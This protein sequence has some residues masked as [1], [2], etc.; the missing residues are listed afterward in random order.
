MA[1][2]YTTMKVHITDNQKDKIMKAVDDNTTVSI[3][4]RH[5]DLTGNDI[6]AFTK[7]QLER[8][9][10][11]YND[12]KGVTIKMSKTQ[13]QYNKKIEGGFLVPL[14]TAA[15]S[16]ILPQAASYLWNKITG[17]GI[18][19][20]RG[21]GI[22]KVKQFGDGLWLKPFKGDGITGEGLFLKTGKGFERIKDA[23]LNDIPI[24]NELLN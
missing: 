18:I 16:A 10:N 20:K 13:V 21:E 23:S 2:R 7:A 19:I 15:A 11:A 24:L 5:E 22:I 9:A 6:V 1:D 12:N 14:L 4:F 8:I 17:K 3:R